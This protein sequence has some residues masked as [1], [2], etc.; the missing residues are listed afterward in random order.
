MKTLDDLILMKTKPNSPFGN[1][2]R[3]FFMNIEN[4]ILTKSSGLEQAYD[5]VK[6]F[7]ED[8]HILIYLQL[9]KMEELVSSQSTHLTSELFQLL[10]TVSEGMFIPENVWK[11][12]EDNIVE[13]VTFM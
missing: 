2:Y 7:D 8:A 5:L 1:Q 11:K 4:L 10:G 12:I 13:N 3:F 6:E 9:Q